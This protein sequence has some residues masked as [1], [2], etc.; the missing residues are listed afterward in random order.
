MTGKPLGGGYEPDYDDSPAAT[1]LLEAFGL[2]ELAFKQLTAS[3]VR[4]MIN[5]VRKNPRELRPGIDV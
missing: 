5:R 2:G 3:E 4:H 1:S